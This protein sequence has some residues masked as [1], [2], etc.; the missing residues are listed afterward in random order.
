MSLVFMWYMLINLVAL[1]TL[2]ADKGAAQ[3]GGWR[4]SE[5]TLHL[6]ALLGGWPASALG[7]RLLRHKTR[8]LGFQGV[9]WLCAATH[10]AIVAAVYG[11]L[12]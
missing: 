9:F 1:L 2:A 5:R 3:R 11:L 12:H 8:K 6:E 4:V 10:C 7:Q